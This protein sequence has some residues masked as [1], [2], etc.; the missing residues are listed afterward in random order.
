MQE[1]TIIQ[2]V[3]EQTHVSIYTFMCGETTLLCTHTS[4]VLWLAGHTLLKK[5]Y[6][7]TDPIAHKCAHTSTKPQEW[8]TLTDIHNCGYKGSPN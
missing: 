2:N 3:I 7:T 6:R 8:D 1:C 5:R 4:T